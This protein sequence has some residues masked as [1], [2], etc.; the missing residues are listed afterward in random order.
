MLDLDPRVDFD[1]VE[2]AG[3]DVDQEL[4]G[5]R[6]FIADVAAEPDGGVADGLAHGRV[7]VVRRRHLDDLLV[8]A[9]NRAVALEKMH[10]AAVLIAQ[11][12]DLDVLG[13]AHELLDEDVGDPEGGP[14]LAAGL[15]ERGVELCGRLD[16]PHAPAAAPHRR[17]DDHRKTQRHGHGRALR[18][19]A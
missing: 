19:R 3:L 17:L 18:P 13:L 8:P 9:L 16:H 5:A 15:V 2:G 11:D 10:E 14:G 6:V 12:L 7:E 4:D 1:E